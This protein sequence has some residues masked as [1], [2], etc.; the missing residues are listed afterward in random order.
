MITPGEDGGRLLQGHRLAGVDGNG[1]R[2]PG[3]SGLVDEADLRGQRRLPA[4]HRGAGGHRNG[5]PRLHRLAHQ[6]HRVIPDFPGRGGHQ[7]VVGQRPVALHA[8][9]ADITVDHRQE[10]EGARPVLGEHRGLQCAR[11]RQVHGGDPPLDHACGATAGV[12][13]SELAGQF[14]LA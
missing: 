9:V 11:V 6:Q 1:E 13:E 2:V 7:V 3:S 5:D 8:A 12:A 4:P 14:G 10:F